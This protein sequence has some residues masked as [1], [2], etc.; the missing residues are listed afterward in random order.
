MF[1]SGVCQGV[2]H[3][4]CVFEHGI[5]PLHTSKKPLRLWCEKVVN[6]K[7]EQ[8]LK[9]FQ[10]NAINICPKN[11]YIYMLYIYPSFCDYL[12]SFLI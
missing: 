8:P 4:L 2:E 6:V 10:K 9:L 1:H 5:G 3:F 11:R 7:A 12:C